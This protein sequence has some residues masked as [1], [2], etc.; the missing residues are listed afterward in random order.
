MFQDYATQ[1]IVNNYETERIK[2]FRI[3][4]HKG[5]DN[6]GLYNT[7]GVNITGLYDRHKV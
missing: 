6:S 4:T 3:I 2:L 7:K 1:S 5:L